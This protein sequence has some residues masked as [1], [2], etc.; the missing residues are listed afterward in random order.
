MREKCNNIYYVIVVNKR[1]ELQKRYRERCKKIKVVRDAEWVEALKIQHQLEFFAAQ[2]DE[3][4]QRL[5]SADL[6][7][8]LRAVRRYLYDA[9]PE[10]IRRTLPDD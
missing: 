3:T 7:V 10:A 8:T 6:A 9:A 1:A 2:G 4:A 5:L